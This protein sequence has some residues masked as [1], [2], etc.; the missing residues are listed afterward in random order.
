MRS[1]DTL[2][3]A[4]HAL[5]AHGARSWLTLL[6]VAFGA[7]SVV[8]LSSLGE[9]ARQYVLNEFTQLGTHLLIVLPGRN[10]TAGGPPPL[11]GETPRDLTLQDALALLRSPHVVRVAPVSIGQAPVSAG[12]LEREVT[13]LGTTAD[14]LDVR[15]LE[16]AAGRFLPIGDAERTPPLA[17]LGQTV[18][19]ELFG[20]VN[21]IGRRVR[22]GDWRVRVIGLLASGGVSLGSNLADSAVIPVNTAQA[23]FNNPA[24][25]RILVQTRGRAALQPGAEDVRRIIRERHEGEDDVT[26]ITQDAMLDTFDRILG[27]L[28]LTVA[29][30]AAISLAV[31]GVLIMNVMLV[32]VSQRTA[33]V[34]LLKALG[35]SQRDIMGLFLSEALLLAGVGTLVGIVLAYAGVYGLNIYF[36]NFQLVVPVWAPLAATAVSLG[37][38]LLFGLLPARRA[39]RLD[40][41]DALAGR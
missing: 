10:E 39:A 19:E 2:S 41:V 34:G 8:L 3:S 33:E 5:T 24:L 40:P 12:S 31:A 1:F 6:A 14:Y 16:L 37:A 26:V 17:V 11:L 15:H 13:I 35:A 30:I 32:S 7:A 20:N 22:I 29:S 27:A 21:P 18:A 9:G 38:G 36:A 28:T 23:L 25:F 4:T